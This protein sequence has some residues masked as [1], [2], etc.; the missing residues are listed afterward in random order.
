MGGFFGG[1]FMGL[2]FFFGE[3]FLFVFWKVVCEGVGGGVRGFG[4]LCVGFF[5]FLFF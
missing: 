5:V 2:S 3:G 1:G 4:I